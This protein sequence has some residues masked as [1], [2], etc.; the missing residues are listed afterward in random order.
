MVYSPIPK[1]CYPAS[2]YYGPHNVF[3]D[4]DSD[5][6]WYFHRNYSSSFKY[7]HFYGGCWNFP[8]SNYPLN[9]LYKSPWLNRPYHNMG[10][11]TDWYR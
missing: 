6:P 1:K 4:S 10:N 2:S 7:S 9:A 8:Y 3:I 5:L 11:A